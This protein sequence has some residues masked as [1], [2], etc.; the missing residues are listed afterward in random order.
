MFDDVIDISDYM[1]DK[2]FEKETGEKPDPE[3]DDFKASNDPKNDYVYDLCGVIIHS[4]SATRGHYYCFNKDT[5]DTNNKKWFEFNDQIVRDFSFDAKIASEAYGGEY[6]R[7]ASNNN[8]NNNN[9]N[10]NNSGNNNSKDNNQVKN[11]YVLVYEQRSERLKRKKKI[12]QSR[13]LGHKTKPTIKDESKEN[14]DEKE[15]ELELEAES[16][17]EVSSVI[18]DDIEYKNPTLQ[19]IKKE[20]SGENTNMAKREVTCDR[21][22]K[23]FVE[24]ILENIE[25]KKIK[26]NQLIKLETS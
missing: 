4:G 19:T 17:T 2:I 18:E 23:D 12:D 20:I 9:S 1:Y 15:L 14:K 22:F 13:K 11:A 6:G 21:A 7:V 3:N 5:Y 24:T 10:N 25:K 8:N 16:K 26:H